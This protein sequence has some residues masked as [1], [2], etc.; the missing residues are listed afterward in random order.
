[1]SDKSRPHQIVIVGGGAGG[2]ELASKLGPRLA[3]PGRANV[4]LVDKNLA[5][6][7][8]P[9]LHEVAAGTLNSHD[10]ELDYLAQARWRHF[11]FRLGS[12]DGLDRANKTISLA[13]TPD[14]KG[15]EVIP[16]RKVTYD[17]LI[18]SVGSVTNDFAIPGVRDHCGFLDTRE[19]ADRFH[20]RLLT[21]YFRAH[22]QHGPLREGQLH[23]A[24][25]GAGATG[26][27]LA[28]ELH[29]ST[30][31]LIAYG[32]DRFTPDKD[33]KITIIEAADRILPA[34]P[35]RVSMPAQRTLNALGIK[36]L[37]GERITR[38]THDGVETAA[39]LFIPAEIKV[40]AA[41]VKAPD[42]LRHLDGLETTANN[43]LVVRPTLQTSR[44]E[45]IFAFGDCAACPQP[46][47]DE[48]VPP[49]AQAARQQ[50]ALLLQSMDRRLEG[51]PLP[52]YVYRDY[53]SLVSVSRYTTVWTLMGNLMGKW[54]P[55][56][57]IEGLLARFAYLSLYKMHQLALGGI[58]RV[59]LLTLANLLTRRTKPRLKLH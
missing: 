31:Q 24:I 56:V 13:P 58:V 30:R 19:Q 29:N 15:D 18:I 2:I 33:M 28:A 54:S 9:L 12:M 47:T 22:T 50:A 38:A 48:L 6:L 52:V 27:E 20:Q 8:K 4:T 57:T 49:R 3:K 36:V 5:H 14:E 10:D 55:Y 34:L 17:T 21:A 45:N 43:Q 7:W 39:G 32:L 23:I 53:G 37:T 11:L 25:V 1:M 46:G 26:V 51:G 59:I 16:R 40:W 41:G 44:D 35:A 42:L